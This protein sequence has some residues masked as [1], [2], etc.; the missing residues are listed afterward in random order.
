MKTSTKCELNSKM[1]FA[2]IHLIILSSNVVKLNQM[3]NITIVNH[4]INQMQNIV[5]TTIQGYLHITF[6]KG[7]RQYMHELGYICKFIF[8]IRHILLITKK[9]VFSIS[10]MGYTAS[11][12]T[13]FV[14]KYVRKELSVY[15]SFPYKPSILI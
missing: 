15:I 7:L 6:Y 11:V 5:S 13:L 2:Q 12:E 1:H 10:K 14:L 8:I 9:K 4:N 3:H